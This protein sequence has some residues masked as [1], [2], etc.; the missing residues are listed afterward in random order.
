MRKMPYKSCPIR[1]RE[2]AVERLLLGESATR[3][4]ERTRRPPNDSIW[5]EAQSRTATPCAARRQSAR[6]FRTDSAPQL[7]GEHGKV[8][9]KY[10]F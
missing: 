7:Y 4:G 3:A 6:I 9:V 5:L 1:M 8:S 2:R 10:P